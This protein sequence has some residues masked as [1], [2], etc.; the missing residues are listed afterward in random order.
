MLLEAASILFVA[1][2]VIWLYN[3]GFDV[4][5][6]K[7]KWENQQPLIGLKK[8]GFVADSDAHPVWKQNAE[9]AKYFGLIDS[10][11]AEISMK[12]QPMS[13]WGKSRYYKVKIFFDAEKIAVENSDGQHLSNKG[14]S[15][16]F[17][18]NVGVTLASTYA[19]RKLAIGKYSHP[20]SNQLFAA[21]QELATELRKMGLLPV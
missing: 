8:F 18:W 10:Y 20:G 9:T 4:A 2:V 6:Q 16:F 17:K 12:C 15:N 3:Y 11:P 7:I 14:R 21:A 19:E 5:K 13:L 1:Q